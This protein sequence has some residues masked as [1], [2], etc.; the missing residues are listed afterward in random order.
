LART[1]SAFD[2]TAQES[3]NWW[4]VPLVKA[5]WNKLISGSPEVTFTDYL[6]RNFLQNSHSLQLLSLGSGACLP[7]MTLAAEGNFQN[8]TC[9]DI[10]A[11]LLK[12]AEAQARQRNLGCMEFLC[13]DARNIHLEEATLDIIFFNSSLHHFDRVEILLREKIAPALKPG[14]LLIFNEYVGPNRFQMS[15][16][17]LSAIN[18]G[19]RLIPK[20]YRIRYKTSI[21]K[22]NVAGPGYWRMK[23]ADPSEAVDARAIIPAAHKI[24]EPL[25]EKGF[26]SNV[27]TFILKDIAWHFTAADDERRNILEQLFAF[28]DKWLATHPPDYLVGVYR[29]RS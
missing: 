17:C 15:E 10:A 22:H 5:R 24:F 26:G 13:A 9:V 3:S 25:A 6:Q 27:L 21:I 14:G 23:W 16:E 2:E 18:E 20:K 11:H 7:E 4:D 29:L 1:L 12:V 28:E 8:I 19:L